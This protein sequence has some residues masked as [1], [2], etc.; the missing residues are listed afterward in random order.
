MASL[1]PEIFFRGFRLNP[2]P[3]EAA[4]YYLPQLLAGAP[5]H[6]AIRPFIHHADVYACEP[7]EL[8]RQ[9]HPLPRTGHRFFF[10]HC[11]LQ[12]PHKAGKA[13]RA[14]RAAGAG[15]WHSQGV[16]DVVDRKKVKVGEM[17]KLRYKKGGAYT[18]W[19]MD[20]YSCCLQDAVVG[21]RQYV[22]CNIYVSPRAAPGSAARQ[23]SAAFFATP[24]PAPAPVVI[25]QA[26][27]PKRP[28]PQVAEPPCP[29]R[30]LGAVVAPAPPVV[31]PAASCTAYFAPPRPCVPISAVVL[32]HLAAPR[33]CVPNGSVAPSST[34]TPS[35][36]RSSPASA[37]PP[38]RAPTRLAAPPSRTPA[39]GPPQ[40]VAQPKQQMPPPIPPVVRA[41]HMPVQAPAQHCRSQPSAQTKKK[42][43]DP[44]EAAEPR[45]RDEAEE[46]RVA[47][48]D[49]PS[50]ESPAALQDDDFDEDD[51]AK[52][53]E[54]AMKTADAEEEAAG[55]STMTDDEMEQHI[56][57]LL[58]DDTV[59]V[60]K[61]ERK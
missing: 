37:Q 16:T 48:F 1:G 18:D 14:T 28:A 13:G 8:A 59:I 54:E 12:Q 31:Q 21:D 4:T 52:A 57:S 43:R 38:A 39:H 26:P 22:F 23:E 19:L 33:P 24:A 11:K 10:T 34:S 42:T 44:F 45:E 55:N 30:T 60:P 29:K 41:C 47:A 46:E 3:L 49:L 51:L 6:E 17:R 7:G 53:M 32:S 9:F 50:E 58:G 61:E 25:A 40:P 27:S 5:L 35:V 2:T 20:E 56:F 36:I 15:S